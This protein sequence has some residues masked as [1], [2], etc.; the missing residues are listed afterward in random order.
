MPYNFTSCNMTYLLF[1]RDTRLVL[2]SCKVFD[3]ATPRP[4]PTICK[5]GSTIMCYVGESILRFACFESHGSRQ[6]SPVTIGS[7]GLK[8]RPIGAR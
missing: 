3:I 8:R 2:K 1:I 5:H 6:Y 7:F 4:Q